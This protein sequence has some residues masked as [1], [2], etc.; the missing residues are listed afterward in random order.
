MIEKII[1]KFNISGTLIDVKENN[2]GNINNTYVVTFRMDNGET[3]KY[4]IQK[5]W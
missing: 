1:S 3:K 2:S 5:S 4:L